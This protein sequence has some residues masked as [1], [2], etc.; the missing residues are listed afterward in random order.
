VIRWKRSWP[1]LSE[2]VPL[3][4][5]PCSNGEYI[6]GEPT[7][8][9][10]AIMEL[11]R[12]ECDTAARKLGMSRRSF[13][14]TGAATAICLMAVDKVMGIRGG[15]GY[16]FGQTL[17][18]PRDQ[19][20]NLEFPTAQLDHGGQ[21][22]EFIM[23]LQTHHV[24]S[25]G[26]WRVDNPGY[27]AFF[28]AVWPQSSCGELDR[29][30]CLSRYHYMK[31]LFLDSSTDVYVLSAVPSMPQM[32]LLPT[33]EAATTTHMINTMAKSQRCVMHAFVMPN[34][35]STGTLGYTTTAT[36]S[37]GPV[38]YTPTGVM[39]LF[40]QDEL[41]AME[42]A[43][44]EY[45]DI[46]RAWKIYTPWGDVPNASGWWLDDPVGIRFLEQVQKLGDKYG[47]PKTVCAHKGF[48]LPAF[49]QRTAATR[50]VGV[51]AKQFQDVTFIIYH[52][53]YDSVSQAGFPVGLG[54]STGPYP[55]DT[56]AT[57]YSLNP[58]DFTVASESALSSCDR[59]VLN[60]IKA[61]RENAWDATRF[62]PAGK[63]HGNVP[64]VYAELGSVWREFVSKSAADRTYLLCN[65]IKYVG[66]KHVVWGTDSLW[67]GSPQPM[68]VALRSFQMDPA[69]AGSAFY[70]LP[71]GLDGDVEDPTQPAPTPERTI[72]NGIFGRN[73]AVPYRVDPAA[74]LSALSCDDV[75]KIRD[76]YL[77]NPLASNEMYGPRTRREL[78]SMLRED[79]WW[80]GVGKYQRRKTIV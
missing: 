57:R 60:F 22:G 67:Y 29:I 47:V 77:V 33:G 24:D 72:R 74:T 79:P 32:N 76:G 21:P 36:C 45:G 75:Q 58:A 66:P 56:D 16:A 31:E 69:I 38:S 43:A 17:P 9:Q 52:S 49:D 44:I 61:L 78:F 63:K 13:L 30:E 3:D 54:Q 1:D 7:R 18:I 6:P 40:M 39:P 42:R 27:E 12:Q 62:V 55:D 46:L 10:R 28:A 50:D 15:G 14:R 37:P 71:Y 25:G 68:I 65:L 19:A 5:L 41:D 51:V 4:V 8:E 34:R 2:K 35:G 23:D 53:G 59:G 48:A 80:R 20:C 11:A 70:N 26:L 73:A 64:N